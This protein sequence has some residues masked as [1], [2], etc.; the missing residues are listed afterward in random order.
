MSELKRNF[1]Y[2][3]VLSIS[4]VLFPLITFSYVSRILEPA[5]I[6]TVSF[7]ESVCRYAILIAALGIPI[8]GVRE[9]AKYKDDNHKLAKLCG[10]L[11]IIHVIS[12]ILVGLIYLIIILNSDKLIGSFPYYILGFIMII[13]NVFTLDW[14]FQGTGDFRFITTRSIIIRVFTTVLVIYSVSEPNDGIFFFGFTTLTYLMGGL[15]NYFY[16]NKQVSIIYSVKLDELKKHILPLFFIF[17]STLSISIYVLLDT[18]MLGLI[19]NDKAVGLYSISMKISKV[20][21]ILITAIGAVLIPKLSSSFYNDEH[22]NFKRLIAKSLN[23]VITFSLPVIFFTLGFADKLLLLFA[24][25]QFLEATITLKILS[26]VVFLIGL[27]NVFG[28]QILTTM[29]KDKY[30]TYSVLLG[31]VVSLTL[32]LILIPKLHEIGAALTN[33]TTELI[34][35]GATLFYASKFIKIQI[36]YSFLF[37]SL[38][39][40]APIYFLSYVIS[41]IT[42]DDL[43]ILTLAIVISAFYFV[44]F[45]LYILKNSQIIE[46]KNKFFKKSIYV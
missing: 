19:S 39:L 14:F 35:T 27:S 45:Q 22:E 1:F 36:E 29:G 26:F 6:G 10:E 18:I 32:N 37:K 16:L 42:S 25:E 24:G 43:V 7:V 30:L 38:V 20:P 15:V 17:S 13:S 40:S 44:V 8:Y 21:I 12:T 28:L 34:V 5:G 3:S 11:I 31:T 33:L 46:L 9:V 2:N 41:L 23:F 4:Q